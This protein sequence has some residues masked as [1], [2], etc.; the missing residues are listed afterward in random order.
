MWLGM[1]DITPS[2]EP[3]KLQEYVVSQSKLTSTKEI[4]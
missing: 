1:P 4:F 3:Q 2:I